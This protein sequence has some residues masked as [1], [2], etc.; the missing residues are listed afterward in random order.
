[1]QFYILLN[2]EFVKKA[3]EKL[4]LISND[5]N[6]GSKKH[7]ESTGKQSVDPTDPTGEESIFEE[8]NDITCTPES[9]T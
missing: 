1:L 6:G 4:S 7:V 5:D 9:Y 8:E 2:T 3:E